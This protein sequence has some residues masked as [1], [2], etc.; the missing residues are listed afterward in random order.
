MAPKLLNRSLARGERFMDAIAPPMRSAGM[1]AY[2]RFVSERPIGG[3][4]DRDE[5]VQA[6]YF[7]MDHERVPRDRNRDSPYVR[8][9]ERFRWLC[10]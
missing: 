10:L 7:A 6:I 2:E 1:V 3:C 4:R 9:C 5:L 8:L